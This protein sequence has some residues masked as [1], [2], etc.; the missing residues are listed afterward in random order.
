MARRDLLISVIRAG[1]TADQ[2]LLRKTVDALVTDERKKGH[3]E[4]TDRR[5]RAAEVAPSQTQTSNSRT[6]GDLGARE[7][8]LFLE[9]RIALDDLELTKPVREQ[10]LEL[11]EEHM[12][13]DVLR[14]HG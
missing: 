2:E 13:A 12:R 8:V 11:I 1:G 7:A 6:A 4:P 14:A 5:R 3:H 10:G 9:P